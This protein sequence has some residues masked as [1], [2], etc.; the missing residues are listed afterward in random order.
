MARA[1]RTVA[2]DCYRDR[3]TGYAA[4][5]LDYGFE[6]ADG[7][8]FETIERWAGCP[9]DSIVAGNSAAYLRATNQLHDLDFILSHVDDLDA[10]FTRRNGEIVIAPDGTATPHL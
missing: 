2:I 8:T 10:V 1:A 5:L 9:A 7:R 3:P 6:A 4:G